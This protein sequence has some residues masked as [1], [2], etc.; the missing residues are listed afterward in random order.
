MVWTVR[1]VRHVPACGT[2]LNTE[3]SN[4]LLANETLRA[5]FMTSQGLAMDTP[6]GES[7]EAF[8]KFLVAE[9]DK[10]AKLAKIAG[11]KPQ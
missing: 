11:I 3:I 9:Q 5:K 4:R 6:S 8:A 2:R 7:P 10:Y 1:A